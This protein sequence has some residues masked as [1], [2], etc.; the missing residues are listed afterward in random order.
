MARLIPCLVPPGKV[1]EYPALPNNTQN[2]HH[3]RLMS[4]SHA[5][6]LALTLFQFVSTYGRKVMR[7]GPRPSVVD[8]H[9]Y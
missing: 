1:P 5:C 6:F 4:P 9:P 2:Y 3:L 7:A 8:A